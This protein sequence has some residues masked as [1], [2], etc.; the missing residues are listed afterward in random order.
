MLDS[1]CFPFLKGRLVFRFELPKLGHLVC[2]VLR[3]NFR[4]FVEDHLVLLER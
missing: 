1:H 2:I 4:I 3:P